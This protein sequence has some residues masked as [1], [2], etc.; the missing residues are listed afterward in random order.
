MNTS[1]LTLVGKAIAQLLYKAMTSLT[2]KLLFLKLY[3]QAFG[4]DAAE[5]LAASDSTISAYAS[6]IIA[7]LNSDSFENAIKAALEVSG[8][9]ED[10]AVQKAESAIETA[11]EA[12]GAKIGLD[13]TI[14][15]L[16]VAIA[17]PEIEAKL[18]EEYEALTKTDSSPTDTSISADTSTAA[19]ST[20]AASEAV[21]V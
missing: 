19:P 17:E 5:Q 13:S 10:E 1:T 3:S 16:I 14:E 7:G 2:S 12:V 4:S 20:E 15:A 6:T 18:R 8:L 21:A 11:V 9:T